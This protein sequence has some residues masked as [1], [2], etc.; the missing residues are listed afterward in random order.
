MNDCNGRISKKSDIHLIHFVQRNPGSKNE[1]KLLLRQFWLHSNTFLGMW[2][3]I[4]IK[5][6]KMIQIKINDRKDL[7]L[8]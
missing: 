8:I 2:K 6:F 1:N 3:K 4:V 7:I 5:G